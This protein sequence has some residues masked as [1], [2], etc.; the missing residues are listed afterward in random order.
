MLAS[1]RR[2]LADARSASPDLR[3]ARRG[4][5]IGKHRGL[6]IPREKSLA[7]SSPAPGISPYRVG[8][9]IRQMST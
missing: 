4:G 5:E 3:D 8:A 9:S 2:G 6:K 7:G 1:S